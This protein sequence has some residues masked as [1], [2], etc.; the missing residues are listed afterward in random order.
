[1]LDQGNNFFLIKFEYSHYLFAGGC[2]DIIEESYIRSSSES[3]I[4]KL[5]YKI[6][7]LSEYTSTSHKV[8]TMLLPTSLIF[9]YR[10]FFL[11]L[12]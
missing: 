1:M 6:P 9:T 7:L 5:N 10:P 4:K 3:L 12:Q 11:G 8:R 2:T